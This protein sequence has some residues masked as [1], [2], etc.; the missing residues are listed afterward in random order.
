MFYLAL[1]LWIARGGGPMSIQPTDLPPPMPVA[2]PVDAEQERRTLR[3]LLEMARLDGT[4][5]R[6]PAA[7]TRARQEQ[8]ELLD[9]WLNLYGRPVDA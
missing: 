5:A 6:S 4:E 8:D 1:A 3:V 9:E 7:K 2:P